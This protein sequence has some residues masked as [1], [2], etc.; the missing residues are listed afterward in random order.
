MKMTSSEPILKTTELAINYGGVQALDG[1]N[2]SVERGELRCIIGPNGA[3]KSTFFKLLMG[4]EKPTEGVIAHDGRDITRLGSSQRARL[5]FSV[6]FQNIRAY[7]NLTVYHNLFIPLLRHHKMREIPNQVTG[8]LEQLGLSGTENQTVSG[9]SHGQ[10]Q[11]LAIGMSIASQPDVLLLDEPAAGM[12][13][14]ETQETENLIKRLNNN[15]MT[16]IVI[17]HDMTFIR[18]LNTK[19]TVLHYGHVFAEGSFSEIEDNDD[20]RKI[21]LGNI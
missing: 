17:E 11:W 5:G 4:I 6:K 14:E 8:L 3:G 18:N 12:S 13:V 19:T 21:Y 15:G 2:F 7:Q 1:V 16:I 20:V 9:L 10:I